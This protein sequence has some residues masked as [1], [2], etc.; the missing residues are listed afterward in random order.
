[1]EIHWVEPDGAGYIDITRRFKS[2]AAAQAGFDALKQ[3]VE[4]AF[5][6]PAATRAFMESPEYIAAR[7]ALLESAIPV[8]AAEDL[9]PHAFADEGDNTGGLKAGE[10]VE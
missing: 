6:V 10:A 7:D 5:V 3:V 9:P 4:R 1:M 2:R 8:P